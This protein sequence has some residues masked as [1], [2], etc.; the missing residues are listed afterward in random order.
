AYDTSSQN[1]SR[2]SDAARHVLTLPVPNPIAHAT[3]E[4]PVLKFAVLLPSV[5][6]TLWRK[7]R[8]RDQNIVVVTEYMSQ[9]GFGPNLSVLT[10]QR[11]L[12]T[13]R[14]SLTATFERLSSGQRINHS[15][16]D[17]AGL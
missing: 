17:P 6:P 10:I 8:V 3:K 5:S 13:H 9:I 1:H 16:D 4:N 7:R 12:G 11:A 14:S 15:K 2:K